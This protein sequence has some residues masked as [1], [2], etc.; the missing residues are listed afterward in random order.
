[1][2]K[3]SQKPTVKSKLAS[4]RALQP[5]ELAT[6]DNLP[7]IFR[8]RLHSRSKKL[9]QKAI[10]TPSMYRL[11]MKYLVQL[12]RSKDADGN[13]IFTPH[14]LRATTATVPGY[15]GVHIKKVKHLL[16]HKDISI[17]DGYIEESNDTKKSASHD[18][19]F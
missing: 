10:S 19:Q 4:S 13:C 7:P 15:A 9:G 11:I 2:A 12:P 6:L 5:S 16:G 3:P 18:V 1:M 14:S 8:A 17:T